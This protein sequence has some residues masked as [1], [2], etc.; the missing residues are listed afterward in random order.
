MQD[1]HIHSDN[2]GTKIL[3]MILAI[4]QILKLRTVQLD[5]S[6][7]TNAHACI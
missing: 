1:M 5:N 2:N 4:H 6:N 7:L 3:L